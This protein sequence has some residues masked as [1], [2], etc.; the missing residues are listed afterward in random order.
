MRDRDI[1]LALDDLLRSQ[2]PLDENTIIR[3]EVGLCTGKRRIDVITINSELD[4]YEIKS[5]EDTLYRLSGQAAMYEE[6]FDRAI[7]VT[8]NHHKD[9]ALDLLP[10]WWGVMVTHETMNGCIYFENYREPTL[11]KKHSAFSLAQLLWREEAM[12]ELRLRNKATGLSKKAR[13]YIWMA[14]TN[15]VTMDELRLIVRSRL[16]ERPIWPGGDLRVQDD[17]MFRMPATV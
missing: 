15:T 14:L 5:D 9:A 4:G 11:N 12:D 2:H 7:L 13:H 8:T 10:H 17:V 16:K 3:H 6:I 1:R